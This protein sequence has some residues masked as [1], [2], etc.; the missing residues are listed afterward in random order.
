MW[1]ILSN[2]IR[3][4]IRLSDYVGLLAVLLDETK[5]GYESRGNHDP[6]GFKTSSKTKKKQNNQ[7]II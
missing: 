4:I 7:F 1:R 6:S 5:V 3:P 2:Y